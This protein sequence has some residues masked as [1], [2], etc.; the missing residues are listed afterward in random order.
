[1]LRKEKR[2]EETAVVLRV[3]V[4]LRSA[5]HPAS[6]Q[7]ATVI[8]TC[9]KSPSLS[10]WHCAEAPLSPFFSFPV[11]ESALQTFSLKMS[12]QHNADSLRRPAFL[13]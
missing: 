2:N 9:A 10:N 4:H 8:F 1:M 6:Q 3:A 11:I 7:V 5:Q 12:M 13:L